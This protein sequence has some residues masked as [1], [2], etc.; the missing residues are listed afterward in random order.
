MEEK[1]EDK[2]THLLLAVII[3]ELVGFAIFIGMHWKGFI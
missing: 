3:G 2:T 1:Q